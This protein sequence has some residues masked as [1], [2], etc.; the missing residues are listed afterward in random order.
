MQK[1]VPSASVLTKKPTRKRQTV[2]VD[3]WISPQLKS[4]LKRIADLEQLSLSRMIA[5][6]LAEGIRQKL[7]IQHAILLQPIIETTL[8]REMRASN[9][10][11]AMLLVRCVFASEQTR[12]LT[13][14]IL[15]RQ[16][17]V[18]QP[19]LEE[20]LDGSSKVAKRNITQLTPQLKT[21]ISEIKQWL[22]EE[23]EL[24]E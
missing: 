17:G 2:H 12:S 16:Q 9:N 13:T 5:T 11:L 23:E 8:K 19:V 4:E 1:T 21:L 14:N 6:I 3:S 10:R 7:H 22:T 24:N 15:S 20:I 18:T